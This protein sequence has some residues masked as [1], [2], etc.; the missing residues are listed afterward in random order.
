MFKLKYFLILIVLFLTTATSA[1][2]DIPYELNLSN[3]DRCFVFSSMD[4]YNTVLAYDADR[5]LI[6]RINVKRESRNSNSQL[7]FEPFDYVYENYRY[8]VFKGNGNTKYVE[9]NPST[10]EYHYITKNE[11]ENVQEN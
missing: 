6:A 4:W 11:F 8:F 1:Q 3:S 9:F 7:V 2:S 5:N 10:Q